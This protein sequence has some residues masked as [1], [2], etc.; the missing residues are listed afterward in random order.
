MVA[1]APAVPAQAAPARKGFDLQAHRGGIG[2]RPE[3]TLASFGN[4]LRLGVSTLELD[5]QITRDGA[6]VVTHDRKV[7]AKKCGPAYAGRFVKD[8]TL[9][10]VRSMDCGGRT[11]PE[12]PGQVAVPGA[13]MPLLSEVFDLVHTYRATGVKLN[14]ETKAG[15]GTV[16]ANWQVHDPD[17]PVHPDPDWYLRTSP[18][19]YS[20]PPIGVL[21]RRDHLKVVPYT[22]DD[23]ATMQRLIDLGVDGLITDGQATAVLVARRTGL[24]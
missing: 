18:A 15:V 5:V 20:G 12:F 23:E 19:Y 11:L 10:Q 24:R 3:N 22:I 7:D 2:L 4:A 6:A 13:R 21:H 8:L 14:V 1:A 17:Q 16:S 9:A